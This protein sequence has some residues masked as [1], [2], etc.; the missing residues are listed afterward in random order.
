MI[1]STLISRFTERCVWI[2]KRVS[3]DTEEPAAPEGGGGFPDY[4]MIP[5]HCLR[6]YL[7]TTY[8]M[9]IDLL[10]EMPR[11]TREIGLEPSDLPHYS[12]LCL[13][14]ERLEMRIC[15][16]LLGQSAQL[17]DTGDIA[18]IDATYFDR[19]PASRHYCRR[20][21]YRVQTL[22]ATKL[23]DTETQVILDLYCTM[24]WEGSDAEVCEQLAR[25]HAGE[26]RVLTADKGYDC[27]WLREDLRELG[28]RPLIKHCIN[29]P[30]DH[31]HN[32]R[33]NEELYGQRSMAETV[34]SSVKRSLGSALRARTWYR[35]FRE[36]TLMCVVYNMKKAAKQEIPL[37][38]CD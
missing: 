19:S 1:V 18:A 28:I 37:P 17:H 33:I 15:R 32:A 22:E 16:V 9:T 7:D 3:D 5:L 27:N 23:I 8:R 31:A 25:R 30:Y 6:I 38:S 12:T 35:E 2:A 14:F 10:R 34:F 4:V 20:T 13:A 24:T 21:N 36:I 29:K 11:I 26:L